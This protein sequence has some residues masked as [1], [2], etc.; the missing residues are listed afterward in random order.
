[1]TLQIIFPYDFL[2]PNHTDSAL[3]DIL[4]L[5]LFF[6]FWW[7]SLANIMAIRVQADGLVLMRMYTWY[8]INI[9][10]WWVFN[11]LPEP[12]MDVISDTT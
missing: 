6:E 4:H 3:D 9:H 10:S 11:P 12:M 2:Y 7:S 8:M 1:M 5:L